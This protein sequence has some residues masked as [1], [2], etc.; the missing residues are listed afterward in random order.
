MSQPNFEPAAEP[1][2]DTAAAARPAPNGLGPGVL[3]S[4]QPR[5]K[6]LFVLD[7]LDAEGADTPPPFV[8]EYQGETFEFMNPEDID[9]QD[10]MVGQDNPRLMLHIIL[11]EAQRA[12]FMEK[13]LPLRLMKALLSR[14][15]EHFNLPDPGEASGSAR[16]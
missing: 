15:N 3:P 16:S 11:P 13:K 1:A 12:A 14:W 4:Q 2:L 6:A 10:L 9:W 8:F 5:P 7:D